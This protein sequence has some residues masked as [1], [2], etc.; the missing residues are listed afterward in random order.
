MNVNGSRIN[1]FRL[2]KM[3]LPPPGFKCSRLLVAKEKED[4]MKS[5]KL[6]IASAILAF[7]FNLVYADNSIPPSKQADAPTQGEQASPTKSEAKGN[8]QLA[9]E[10]CPACCT[11]KC[12]DC[13]GCKPSIATNKS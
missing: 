6:L 8:C 7:G 5:A 4:R 3:K 10:R 11:N 12:K 13:S 2:A 9:G 1:R